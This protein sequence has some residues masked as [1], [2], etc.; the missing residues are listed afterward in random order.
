MLYMKWDIL[1]LVDVFEK[2]MRKAFNDLRR[3]PFY[4]VNLPE[5]TWQCG[6][7]KRG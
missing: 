6:L 7:Q 1:I 4:S 2:F 5:Y 3:N